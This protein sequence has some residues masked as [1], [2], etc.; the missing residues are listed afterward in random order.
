MAAITELREQFRMLWRQ[1]PTPD[2]HATAISS[3]EAIAE[4]REQQRG[5]SR[6]L[7][8]IDGHAIS[9]GEL[10]EQLRTVS[11]SV[12]ATDTYAAAISELREQLAAR[13]L[14]DARAER[15]EV[16]EE[17]LQ[18]S[19]QEHATAIAEHTTILEE[20]RTQLQAR[21]EEH[22]AVLTELRAQLRARVAA[23]PQEVREALEAALEGR[24]QAALKVQAQALEASL[25]G[26]MEELRSRVD[27]LAHSDKDLRARLD[28]AAHAGKVEGVVAR[29]TAH[30][31]AIAEIRMRLFELP[32]Q[33]QWLSVLRAPQAR[34]AEA[35][36]ALRLRLEEVSHAGRAAEEALRTRMQAHSEE[37]LEMQGR[38]VA[39]PAARRPPLPPSHAGSSPGGACGGAAEAAA[40]WGEGQE[41]PEAAELALSIMELEVPG[42][43]EPRIELEVEVRELRGR[44]DSLQEAMDQRVMLSVWR[45]EKQLPEAMEKVERLLADYPERIAKVE[46]ND[47]RL[48]LA[49]ARLGTQEHKVQNCMERLE[50]LPS[51]EQIRKICR[52]ELGRRLEDTDMEGLTRSVELQARAIEELGDRM[53]EVCDVVCYGGEPP[54]EELSAREELAGQ[55]PQLLQRPPVAPVAGTATGRP[56][57][58]G[59]RRHRGGSE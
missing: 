25:Q 3:A 24:L 18:R 31:E 28:D 10:R 48:G 53:Q 12:A 49:L 19:T 20:L 34:Q 41:S 37:M 14:S 15:R 16:L 47:V 5:L 44:C 52:E 23:A 17:V 55:K 40:F 2:A 7:A 50:R 54:A 11:R 45:V 43:M 21:G 35:L 57:P 30:E 13:S 36:E 29:V 8:A 22:T 51:P 1:T 56:F 58:G 39:A 27:E 33:E 6:Q 9:I 32:A 42:A 59:G 46:E 4:L 26:R 38:L